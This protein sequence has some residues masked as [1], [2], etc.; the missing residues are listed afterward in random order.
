MPADDFQYLKEYLM[1]DQIL[2]PLDRSIEN[3]ATIPHLMTLAQTFRARL[4]ILHVFEEK[5]GRTS[6]DP[7]DWYMQKGKVQAHLNQVADDLLESEL[8]AAPVLLDGQPGERILAYADELQAS[9]IVLSAGKTGASVGRVAQKVISRS[10]RSLMILRGNKQNAA[11]Y[12]R[13]LVPLDGSKRAECVLPVAKTLAEHNGATLILAHVV[14]QPQMFGGSHELQEAV[15]EVTR[16]NREEGEAYLSQIEAHLDMPCERR[17]VD[18]CDRIAALHRLAD[19]EAADLVLLSAHGHSCRKDQLYGSVAASFAYHGNTSLLLLQ[20]LPPH[21]IGLSPAERAAGVSQD[22]S[23][24]RQNTVPTI[25][26]H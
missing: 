2:A 3:E 1:F 22:P 7:L 4:Q 9:M 11:P 16:R 26:F 14:A 5:E 13:I 15:C 10:R 23:T 20:D 6:V 12:R 21:E 25:T 17:L 19:R 8:D 24:R 18:A